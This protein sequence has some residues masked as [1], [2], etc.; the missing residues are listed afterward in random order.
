MKHAVIFAHPN[1]KGFTATMAE[2]YTRT[3]RH[4]GHEVVVRDLYRMGFDPCLK[5]EELPSLNP[6]VP[7]ADVT[8][9]REV[10]RDAQV[11]VFFYPF[12]FNAPPA[13]LTGYIDRVF[14]MGFGYAHGA[15][16][17]EPMLT[18]RKLLSFTSSGAPLAWVR[19]TGAW[20]AVRKLFDEHIAEVCGFE[21]VDHVHF[22]EITPGIRKDAVA[23]CAHEVTL[24]F[25]EHFL[26]KAP[27]KAGT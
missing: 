8:A 3:A 14:G 20:R 11:F 1:P 6:P 9:E 12:W 23:D 13:M 5:L 17:M 24:A 22:G 10:I 27:V 26:T 15:G 21:L 25:T 16:G 19:D 7:G 2:A 4:H 18:G